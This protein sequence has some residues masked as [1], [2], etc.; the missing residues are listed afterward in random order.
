MRH[1][2]ER[3]RA[4]AGVVQSAGFGRMGGQAGQRLTDFRVGGGSAVHARSVGRPA[5]KIKACGPRNSWAEWV[6]VVH[7]PAAAAMNPGQLQVLEAWEARERE[8]S[9]ELARSE[10]T[11]Y[12]MPRRRSSALNSEVAA[13]SGPDIGQA[14]AHRP[15]H[16]G[17][18]VAPPVLGLRAGRPH[19]AGSPAA[20]AHRAPVAGEHIH[21]GVAQVEP[22]TAHAWTGDGPP[23]RGT[24]GTIC[25]P[26]TW[27]GRAGRVR[28][29]GDLLLSRAGPRPVCTGGGGD[30]QAGRPWLDGA[31]DTARRTA[32]SGACARAERRAAACS[33]RREVARHDR[34][35]RRP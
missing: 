27:S 12:S 23:A 4:V 29:A 17:C 33:P 7:V 24:T 35:P 11:V 22:A 14:T 16:V 3:P 25:S 1:G 31:W 32:R 9:E 19:G 15:R 13:A 8:A 6:W 34:L 2:V 20:P 30:T 21:R 5:G 10:T 18:A 26:G 28:S